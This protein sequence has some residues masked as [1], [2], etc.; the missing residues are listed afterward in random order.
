MLENRAWSGCELFG[1][2]VTFCEEGVDWNDITID[3]GPDEIE[4][5]SVRKVW[6]EMLWIPLSYVP[7]LVTFCEEGVDWNIFC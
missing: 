5:P 6:I 2:A 7:T 1:F 4:S 3:N